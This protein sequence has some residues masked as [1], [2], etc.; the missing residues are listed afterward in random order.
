MFH[1]PWSEATAVGCR[2][3]YSIA[4]MYVLYLFLHKNKKSTVENISV[5]GFKYM[6]P[7]F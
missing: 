2:T 6:I 5:S 1:N 3:C 7:K 4:D